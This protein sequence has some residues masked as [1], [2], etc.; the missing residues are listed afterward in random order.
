MYLFSLKGLPKAAALTHASLWAISFFPFVVGMNST[1]VLYVSLPL[2]HTAAFLSVL[3]AIERGM[4]TLGYLFDKMRGK[5]FNSIGD[6][7]KG[8]RWCYS[9]FFYMH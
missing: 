8:Y 1:D 7:V 2:Y 9:I 4:H 3:G 6:F 5:S